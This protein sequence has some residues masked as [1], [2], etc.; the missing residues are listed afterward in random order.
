MSCKKDGGGGWG[1]V[2]VG[3]EGGR[4]IWVLPASLGGLSADSF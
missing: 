3:D 2:F 4:V 1:R